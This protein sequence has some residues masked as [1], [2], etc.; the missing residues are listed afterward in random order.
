MTSNLYNIEDLKD[1][2]KTNNENITNEEKNI[3]HYETQLKDV[4]DRIEKGQKYRDEWI[5]KK[6]TGIDNDL[7]RANPETLESEINSFKL[8]IHNT[9]SEIDLL[10]LVEPTEYYKEDKH[11][12]VK[13]LLSESKIN[14]GTGVV[15]KRYRK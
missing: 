13:D 3:V 11:D 15:D 14:V 8:K 6:H 12:N 1:N 5:Q 7:L 2:I 9:K 10:N 4:N